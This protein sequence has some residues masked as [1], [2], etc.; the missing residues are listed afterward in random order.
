MMLF[1]CVCV[2]V[3]VGFFFLNFFIKVYIAGTHLNKFD[4]IQMSTHNICLI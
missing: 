4:A 1:E 2:C 3:F